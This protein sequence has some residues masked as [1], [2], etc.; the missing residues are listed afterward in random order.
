M[1]GKA[2]IATHLHVCNLEYTKK[3]CLEFHVHCNSVIKFM[4]RKIELIILEKSTMTELKQFEQTRST[5]FILNV[6]TFVKHTLDCALTIFKIG[7]FVF[8]SSQLI[9]NFFFLRQ[10]KL[11]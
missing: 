9:A 6:R 11:I 10:N 5:D 1:N 2:L 3:N 4:L 7:Y 8:L